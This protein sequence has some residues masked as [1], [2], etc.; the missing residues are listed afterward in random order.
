MKKI[1]LLAMLFLLAACNSGKDV[2]DPEILRPI[3][4]AS[5]SEEQ[6]SELKTI[7]SDT[8]DSLNEYSDYYVVVLHSMEEFK[9]ICPG[10]MPC[11][12]IDFTSQSLIFCP[13][14]LSSI[15]DEITDCSLYY[16]KKEDL[17]ELH[18]EITK[19]TECYDALRHTYAYNMFLIPSN[20]IKHINP[21]VQLLSK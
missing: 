12:Q 11:P 2:S 17:Y 7:F 15:N 10:W 20:D 21:A 13:L 4:K 6:I 19:C 5:L 16:N 8:N 1:L 3:P 9:A 18:V 14:V